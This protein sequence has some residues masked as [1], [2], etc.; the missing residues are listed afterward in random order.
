MCSEPQFKKISMPSFS[1]TSMRR[2]VPQRKVQ[3]SKISYIN[4]VGKWKLMDGWL[5]RINKVRFKGLQYFLRSVKCESD[6]HLQ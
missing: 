4:K 3:Y 2:S 1:V 5:D 6:T